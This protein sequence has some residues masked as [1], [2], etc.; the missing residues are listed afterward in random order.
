MAVLDPRM[1]PAPM[2]T[3]ADLVVTWVIACS[4]LRSPMENYIPR[5]LYPVTYGNS[6]NPILKTS[7]R[8]G[9]IVW[10]QHSKDTLD[11]VD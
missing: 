10:G 5:H 2:A 6:C 7:V 8:G 9:C 11:K 3:V 1:H 4:H